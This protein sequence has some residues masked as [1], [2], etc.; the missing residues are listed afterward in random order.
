MPDIID[1]KRKCALYVRVS[2]ANQAEEGESLDEQVRTLESYCAYR[3]WLNPVIYREE[4]FS[5]KNLKRPAFQQMMRDIDKGKINTVIVKK[6]D[7]L[8]RS[9]MDFEGLYT[10]FQE[11]NV[12]RS[13]ML[14]NCMMFLF[15]VM[16]KIIQT[17]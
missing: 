7:R 10:L 15:V 8:S 5:G 16:G 11:S 14:S 4:G 6:I 17:P 1:N 2:T 3:K 13:C 12:S 9:I